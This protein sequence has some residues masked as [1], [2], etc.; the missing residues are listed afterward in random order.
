MDLSAL[1]Y[2]SPVPNW[3]PDE[4]LYSL[5][6]R[7][8]VLAGHLTPKTTC[9]ILF[10]H[11]HQGS[12]HDFP[13]HLSTFATRTKH[14]LGDPQ[15]LA[16]ERTILPFYLRLRSPEE[17]ADA[18]SSMAGT[19]SGMLKYRLGIVTSRF[20]ANHPLKACLHC[21]AKDRQ[22]Y[23]VAYWHLGHQYPGVWVCPTHGDWLR[24]STLKASG[25]LRF[26]WVLPEEHHL[27]AMQ[28]SGAPSTPPDPI[29]RLANLVAGMIRLP[30]DVHLSADTLARTYRMALVTKGLLTHP[31]RLRDLPRLG[32]Q[33]CES[34][35]PLR[36]VSEL[37]GLPASPQDAANQ[38][39][40]CLRA[41]R[42]GTHP[43]RQ[44]A[45]VHW[46]F[47]DWLSFWAAYQNANSS[48]PSIPTAIAKA[49]TPRDT[50]QMQ[51]PSLLD[52]GMSITGSA[53]ALGV[54]VK[55]AMTWAAQAGR[56]P[57]RRPKTLKGESLQTLI[58]HLHAGM[59][60]TEAATQF[61]IS[62]ATVT[63]IL[64]TEVGLHDAW[65]RA[66]M[67]HAR[68]TARATWQS[69]ASQSPFLGI[70]ALRLQHPTA[71]AWL[72]RNDRDWLRNHNELLRT[73]R[74]DLGAQRIDWDAR[75]AMLA[76]AVR[77]IAAQ[78]AEESGNPK[79][80]LWQI[81]QRLPVLKAK[82][83]A[84]HR[85][86]LTVRAIED[87]TRPRKSKKSPRLV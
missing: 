73:P 53:R 35:A 85:L 43:L 1:D 82:L 61:C 46:L 17:A 78:I 21:M 6:S 57:P 79:A 19:P 54:D 31:D 55:T 83:G 86:P 5:A 25:V 50:R 11:W 66:R 34:I 68:Q 59:D 75:D 13:C 44:L 64:H 77:Q 67:L 72:Y 33:F 63:R 41:P 74:R 30:R 39:S 71:Y 32:A 49:A 37:Y 15:T 8:H 22:T 2:E 65:Q 51:L 58:A 24:Q 38:L 69:A 3:L 56:Q 27:A 42:S 87:A 28:I 4:T 18:L 60:K 9:Q 48:R 36:I 70:K 80:Q 26:G 62:V 84:L 29:H 45:I 10:G 16:L 23:G 7:Y 20:R 14:V 47:A 81:Y 12:Q 52:G 40:R 76:T